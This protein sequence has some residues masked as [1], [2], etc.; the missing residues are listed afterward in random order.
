MHT[1]Y[2]IH[3]PS[4]EAGHCQCEEC[5]GNEV[6]ASSDEVDDVLRPIIVDPNVVQDWGEEVSVNVVSG[7]I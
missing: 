7:T 2:Q 4:R 3:S 5:I 1:T 6:P